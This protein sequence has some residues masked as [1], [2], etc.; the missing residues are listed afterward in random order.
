MDKDTETLLNFTE[1]LKELGELSKKVNEDN[2]NTVD[3]Y[4]KLG[5]YIS[6]LEHRVK[7]LEEENI[8]LRMMLKDQLGGIT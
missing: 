2:I 4:I 5:K 1:T 6:E 8:Y 3:S 7:T